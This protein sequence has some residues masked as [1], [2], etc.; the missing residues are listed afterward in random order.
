[1]K[2]DAKVNVKALNFQRSMFGIRCSMFISVKNQPMNNSCIC[3]TGTPARRQRSDGQECPSCS[4]FV[5]VVSWLILSRYL[6]PRWFAAIFLLPVQLAAFQDVIAAD[7]PN[8]L[9]IAVDDLRPE[10]GCYD[11]RHI[12]SPNI[13]RLAASGL[14]F[15]R[16]YVQQSVCGPSRISLLSGLRPDSTGIYNN[17]HML[18]DMRPSIVSL[19][20]HFKE[21]GYRTVSLG[22]IYHHP[23][24]DPAAWSEPVWRPFGISWGWRNYRR[25]ENLEL[26][27]ELHSQLP[28]VRRQRT[29][30]GRVKGPA[31]ES[32]PQADNVYPDGLTADMAIHTLR[33]LSHDHQ[34][35]FLAVGF[36]KPHLPFACPEK[37]WEMYERS[38]IGLPRHG[39]PPKNMPPVAFRDSDELR[40]YHGIPSENR[41]DE[42]LSRTL[43]HGYRAC[44]TYTDAQVGRV[45]AELERLGLAED[46]TVVLWGDHGWHLGE[47]GIWAKQT[48]F[49][50]ATRAPLIVRTPAIHT[51]GSSTS[52]LVEM[53][54]IY[55]TL[56][57]LAG[58]PKP[59]HLE[60]TSFVPLLDQPNRR[61]KQA[62]LSQYPRPHTKP[63][64]VLGRTI[65]TERYRFTRWNRTEEPNAG[66]LNETVAWE[67]YDHLLDPEETTNIADTADKGLVKQL[68]AQLDS[69]W[70]GA[71]PAESEVATFG[72]V[73]GEPG[74]VQLFNGRDLTG[75][76]GQPGSW[77]VKDGAI[78]CTGTS[79]GRNWLI[80]RGVESADFELRLRF[81]FTRGNSGVQVRSTDVG[82]WQV[83]GYQV[84]VAAKEKM[85]LWHHSLLSNEIDV[86]NRRKHLATA[87]QRVYIGQ[88]AEKNVD[89][90]AQP[91][92]IQSV[93]QD[94]QWNEMTI[95]ARGPQLIQKINGVVFADLTDEQSVF[96]SRSGVIAFQDHG[97]GTAVAFKDIR[98]QHFSREDN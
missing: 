23:E 26:V 58:L 21:H 88:N 86:E 62:A 79:K 90:F 93:F 41:L 97:K 50:L 43:I 9:M 12:V 81:R 4:C 31:H 85:G 87:G 17:N 74:F 66:K 78:L 14:V 20:R 2:S 18:R 8:V 65:R 68:A 24:D 6:T 83:R 96:A 7:R 1:M 59:E 77:A 11:V 16:A 48:N 29:P 39:V 19:P 15:R 57:D 51:A 47:Q 92:D 45:L 82:Q 22:K 91:V 32:A 25:P 40:A 44:V 71:V 38:E 30:V 67:L 60:G 34:P 94:D 3:R 28:A 13:D 84:E 55:P 53:V 56:C 69:G 36:Y 61:W 72:E 49:E 63:D 64:H 73:P 46:T 27:N 80:R 52:A 70:R 42:E 89:Q 5:T 75:W 37:Y 35:F 76:D 10:L 54:D 98:I 33:R 95:I